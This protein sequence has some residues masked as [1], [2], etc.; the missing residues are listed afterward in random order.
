MVTRYYEKEEDAIEI[1][2]DADGYR[3]NI[4]GNL[5]ETQL[6]TW[7]NVIKQRLVADGVI[8]SSADV[9]EVIY[10]KQH[11]KQIIP[12][13]ELK[14]SSE[15]IINFWDYVRMIDSMIV[16]IVIDEVLDEDLYSNLEPLILDCETIESLFD[17]DGNYIGSSRSIDEYIVM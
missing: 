10:I 2:V 15:G 13:T 6:K 17:A 8:D 3:F 1:I 7:I 16:Y 11:E 9:S 14:R 5:N 12:K 4:R